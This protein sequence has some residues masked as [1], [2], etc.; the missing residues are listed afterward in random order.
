MTM[1]KS[2]PFTS[3]DER[4]AQSSTAAQKK[5]WF[6]ALA[7][8]IGCGQAPAAS[9]EGALSTSLPKGLWGEWLGD[10]ENGLPASLVFKKKALFE[11]RTKEDLTCK[12]HAVRTQSEVRWYADFACSD[13][14][15]LQID[16]LKLGAKRILISPRPLGE[17]CSYNR[18]P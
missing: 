8:A 18:A 6:F 16:I 4:S 9:A 7:V 1:T 11:S 2:A 17:A 15:V 12:V 14:S 3:R 5:F 13:G 10:C